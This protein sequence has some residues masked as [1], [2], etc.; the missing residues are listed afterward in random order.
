MSLGFNTKK[1]FTLEV[2]QIENMENMKEKNQFI[3][4][5]IGLI[6]ENQIMMNNSDILNHQ[7]E[8]LYNQNQIFTDENLKLN[9]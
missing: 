2:S 9:N 7:I 5:L 6:K 3:N 8:I 1:W 4:I